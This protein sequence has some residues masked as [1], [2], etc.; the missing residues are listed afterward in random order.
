M[1]FMK[2]IACS[3]R[4]NHY[5]FKTNP[6]DE[7]R[8]KLV[9]VVHLCIFKWSLKVSTYSQLR[10]PVT[11]FLNVLFVK[12]YSVLTCLHFEGIDLSPKEHGILEISVDCARSISQASLC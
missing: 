7:Y 6:V 12:P 2:T 8:V 9:H 4:I 3:H 11:V 5:P 10:N 1:D